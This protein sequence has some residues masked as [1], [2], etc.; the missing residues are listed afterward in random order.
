MYV[1]ALRRLLRRLRRTLVTLC[2]VLRRPL[3]R[4]FGRGLNRV[5]VHPLLGPDQE[6]C[7]G[8]EWLVVYQ[9]ARRSRRGG[10]IVQKVCEDRDIYECDGRESDVQTLPAF[11]EAWEVRPGR[12]ITAEVDLGLELYDDEF[13]EADHPGTEGS[14]HIWG[15]LRFFEGVDLPAGMVPNNP[16]TPAGGLPSTTVEPP[17]W[18][19]L[20]STHHDLASY[21]DCCSTPAGRPGLHQVPGAG[22]RGDGEEEVQ[23]RNEMS[24]ED[25]EPRE[26]LPEMT[27]EVA[28][29]LERIERIVPWTEGPYDDEANR[30]LRAVARE[31]SATSGEAI[32]AALRHWADRHRDPGSLPALSRPYLLLRVLFDV[33]ERVLRH[34]A[35]V[36]G[37]W[38]HPSVGHPDAPVFLL[39]WPVLEDEEGRPA[40]RHRFRSYRGPRY[41]P[42]AEYD[43]FAERFR[44]RE[45]DELEG[46]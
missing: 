29:V 42:V 6:R 30:T 27:E 33:P 37:G 19:G 38:N 12:R 44:R 39:S 16:D 18:S 11:W 24:D 9:L 4:W 2:R 32:R 46:P 34:D 20:G 7:G 22:G 13:S 14:V 41:D 3:D 15:S 45:R 31:L 10:W 21:W 36:F 40:V 25:H 5:E 23:G 8:F 26:P 17:F 1:T 35:R 28:G 43:Y